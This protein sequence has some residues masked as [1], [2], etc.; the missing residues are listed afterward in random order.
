MTFSQYLQFT[1]IENT[2]LFFTWSA[3]LQ[4]IEQINLQQKLSQIGDSNIGDFYKVSPNRYK[5]LYNYEVIGQKLNDDGSVF[6][7]LS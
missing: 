7:M 2:N 4:P 3:S 6:I 1:T 5:E